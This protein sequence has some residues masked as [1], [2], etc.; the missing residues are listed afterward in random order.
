[1]REKDLLS[2]G[3]NNPRNKFDR[4]MYMIVADWETRIDIEVK[5]RY[6]EGLASSK[7]KLLVQN[8]GYEENYKTTTF[9]SY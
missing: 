5:V 1:M 2:S 3:P 6:L 7:S 9:W 8:A 4:Y